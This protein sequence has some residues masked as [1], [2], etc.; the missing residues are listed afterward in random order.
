MDRLSI[1]LM[2]LVL[3]TC[4]KR[5]LTIRFKNQAAISI[6][7]MIKPRVESMVTSSEKNLLVSGEGS[8]I[9]SSGGNIGPS[10]FFGGE[11]SGGW[12]VF[13]CSFIVGALA[14][15]AWE[16]NTVVTRIDR[17]NLRKIFIEWND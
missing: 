12:V 3:L 4:S 6:K 13:S 5:V 2:A 9:N 10:I 16:I 14:G 7:A 11:K 1:T 15:G 8:P 17:H